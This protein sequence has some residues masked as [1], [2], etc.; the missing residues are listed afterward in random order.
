MM[1]NEKVRF[2]KDYDLIK[3]K[4]IY[5]KDKDFLDHESFMIILLD[6]H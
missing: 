5:I 1:P 3:N 6:N 4:I 2:F